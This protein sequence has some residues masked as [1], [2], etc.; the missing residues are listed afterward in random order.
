MVAARERLNADALM[1]WFRLALWM[2][3]RKML[4]TPIRT[5]AAVKMSRYWVAAF[6]T[7]SA[8]GRKGA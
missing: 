7:E 6:G 8:D 4:V 2:N 3:P 5:A 1:A